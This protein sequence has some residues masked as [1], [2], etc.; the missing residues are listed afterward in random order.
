M[1]AL[2]RTALALAALA[3]LPTCAKDQTAIYVELSIDSSIQPCLGQVVAQVFNPSTSPTPTTN[4][5]QMFTYTN[6]TSPMSFLVLPRTDTD[7]VRIE[8]AGIRGSGQCN[9]LGVLP[10]QMIPEG[11]V[12]VIDR[13]IVQFRADTVLKLPLALRSTCVG[14]N[15]NGGDHC[16]GSMRTGISTTYTCVPATVVP[17]AY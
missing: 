7:L 14:S 13:A 11:Q 2:A 8:V 9:N 17:P 1:R 15:C 4:G 5:T 3:T 16:T 12:A 10:M 6:G